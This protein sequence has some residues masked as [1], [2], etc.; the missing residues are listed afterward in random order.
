MISTL[1]QTTLADDHTTHT[2]V[3]HSHYLLN[4]KANYETGAIFNFLTHFLLNRPQ[5]VYFYI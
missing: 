1:M 2:F 4:K 5:F 3:I